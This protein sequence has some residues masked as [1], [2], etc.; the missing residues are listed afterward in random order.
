[1]RNLPYQGLNVICL[2]CRVPL[3]LLGLLSSFSFHA[4][5]SSP[6]TGAGK[7]AGNGTLLLRPVLAPAGVPAAV[8]FLG[9]LVSRTLK[10]MPNFAEK[11]QRCSGT[12]FL[13]LITRLFGGKR[14]YDRWHSLLV[15]AAVIE[16]AHPETSRFVLAADRCSSVSAE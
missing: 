9:W 13:V 3:L 14:M 6:Q 10:K 11:S 1:M 12:R 15:G 8:L 4:C 7:A 5:L 16:R 2:R